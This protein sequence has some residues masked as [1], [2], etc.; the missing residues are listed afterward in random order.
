MGFLDK[1]SKDEIKMIVDDSKN[2]A[3]VLI[4]MGR[5]ANSGSNRMLIAQYTKDNQIDTSHF[6]NEAKIRTPQDIFIEH[7]TATQ[8]IMRKYYKRGNYSE[9]KCAICGQ[10]PFWN[11]KELVLTLDHI[12]GVSNDHRLENLRWICPN[13]DRQLPTYG[14]K[15]TKK[16]R[17]CSCC[18]QPIPKRNKSGL[19]KE[20][21]WEDYRK[22]ISSTQIGKSG[23]IVREKT[24]PT[25]GKT[26]SKDA[27]I[28]I[29][30]Y[31]ELSRKAQRPAP[32]ELA[33]MIKE[34]GFKATGKRFGVGG[35]A[36]VK[37]CK[38]YDIPYTKKEL[39]AWYDEQVGIM[40]EPKPTQKTLAEI[41][42]PVKQIDMQTGEVL[43]VFAN[44]MD[45]LRFLGRTVHNNH[46][47]QVCRGIRK[48]AYGYYWQYAD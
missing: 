28:C 39:I 47:S 21:Y 31:H 37:W 5:S 12:N 13:C 10:E 36:V 20:C 27:K 46:I 22:K 4:K 45:A 38:A 15:R 2:F 44:Q 8:N 17:L 26:I 7:S 16:T 41:V 32:M 19:C 34:I 18:G 48:S 1:Y 43:N 9:Y 30:C 25:C 35:N 24:C 11:G 40:P 6:E 23:E 29:N 3:E 14:S 42:H 33:K